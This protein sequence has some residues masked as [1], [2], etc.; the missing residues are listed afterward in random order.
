MKI[1]VVGGGRWARTIAGVLATM[2]DRSERITVH[3]PGNSAAV[4]AWI[5]QSRLGDRIRAAAAWPILEA[6][7]NHPDAVVIANR[8]GDHF[9]AAAMALRA[10]IPT[11]VE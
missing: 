10:G 8:A 5:G 4:A 3:S 9:A 11:L 7:G 2:P 6:G 1:S